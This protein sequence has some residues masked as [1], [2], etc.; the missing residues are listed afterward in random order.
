MKDKTPIWLISIGLSFSILLIFVLF[1]IISINGIKAFWPK[2]I[3]IIK[4]I[5]QKQI[6]GQITKQSEKE[7]QIFT[8]NKEIYGFSFKYIPQSEI[9]EISYPKDYIQAKRITYGDSLLLPLELRKGGRTFFSDNPKFKEILKKEFKI[10]REKEKRVLKHSKEIGKVNDK[11]A[12]LKDTI[13]KNEYFTKTEGRNFSE[14]TQKIEESIAYFENEYSIILEKI[15]RIQNNQNASLF[16]RIGSKE[17]REQPLNEILSYH[18]VNNLNTLQKTLLFGKRIFSFLTESPR[19]SNTEGGIFPAIVGTFLMT[20]I[21]S[22]AVTPIGIITALYLKEYT[23]N[24]YFVRFVRI[25]INNLAGV[26][27]IIFGVFGLGFFVYT[28]GYSIDSLLYPWKVNEP[29]W[30]TG[31]ILWASLTLALLTLPVVIVATEESFSAVPHGIK[32]AALACGCSKWQMIQRIVLPAS[33]PGILTGMILAMARGAGEVAP[34]MLV[35]VVKLA[36]K[37]PINTNPPFGLDQ[38]FMHLGFH[39]Y[40]L[41]F[42]SPDSE[43]AK[44]LVFATILTLI[45]LVIILNFGAIK[46]RSYLKKKY[47][48][49]LF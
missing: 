35:G 29:V 38:K 14:E 8:G 16:Y 23:N 3:A 15:Q 36:P 5:D 39:I 34:L 19:E 12:S 30:G 43:A 2:R 7:I 32:E 17:T 9:Q 40:D 41:G 28:F 1:S 48:S 37:I 10:T 4:L 42:Q 33:A 26:P 20:V 45:L 47:Q 31:G 49:S 6:A 21:M 22:L 11:I 18:Y 27:S 44:P 24:G 46:L 13:R 25:C